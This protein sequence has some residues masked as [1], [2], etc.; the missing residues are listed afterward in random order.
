MNNL[1]GIDSWAI[2]C[3]LSQLYKYIVYCEG[4]LQVNYWSSF[5]FSTLC[6]QTFLKS[7]AFSIW[8][9]DGIL[10]DGFRCRL[11]WRF[12]FPCITYS[13]G[14]WILVFWYLY[15]DYLLIILLQRT[16]DPGH[17]DI[18]GLSDSNMMF[19]FEL[20]GLSQVSEWHLT[21][22]AAPLSSDMTVN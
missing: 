17:E 12:F 22:Y 18:P 8:I 4:Y 14:T 11:M 5:F 21:G 1:I 16:I 13:C 19:Y 3:N 9:D 10:Y 6:L 2:S 15:N 7:T 20:C